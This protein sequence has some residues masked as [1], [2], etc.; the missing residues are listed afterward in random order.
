MIQ[1]TRRTND[2]LKKNS[3]TKCSQN[4]WPNVIAVNSKNQLNNILNKLTLK[5]DDLKEEAMKQQKEMKHG[6]AQERGRGGKWI[7][8]RNQ[9]CVKPKESDTAENTSK[10]RTRLRKMSKAKWKWT[11]NLRDMRKWV[12][13]KEKGVKYK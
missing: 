11:G 6:S 1:G 7:C 5:I 13:G 4:L 12:L 8:Y 10:T 2:W 3:P 9:G